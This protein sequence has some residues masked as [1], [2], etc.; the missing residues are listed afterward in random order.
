[1]LV[2]QSGQ[3]E[4]IRESEGE[5]IPLAVLREGEFFGEM[6]IFEREARTATVRALGPVRVLTVDKRTLLQRIQEDPSLAFRMVEVMSLRIRE[7]DQILG[8]RVISEHLITSKDPG[9]P[10]PT[11][12]RDSG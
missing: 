10:L 11:H 5:E 7:V 4:V 1:M 2:I 6:A 9:S 8:L 12:T 3:V